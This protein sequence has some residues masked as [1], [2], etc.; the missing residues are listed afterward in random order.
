[1]G[2]LGR[3]DS[4]AYS[5]LAAFQH[6]QR[7]DLSIMRKRCVGMGHLEQRCRQPVAIRH[8]GLFDRTPC[9]PGAQSARHCTWKLNLWFLPITQCSIGVPHLM[10]GHLLGDLECTHVTGFLD[11]TFNRQRAIV[12]RVANG[13]AANVE[14]AWACFNDGMGR[15]A[16]RFQ[17]HSHGDRLHRRA[18]L[19]RVG[20]RAIAQLLTGQV[21]ALVGH[22]AGIICEGQHF[23]GDRV[24][25]H[26]AARFGPVKLYR[27]AQLLVSD[28]LYLAVQAQM[29]VLALQWRYLLAY[30]FHNSAEPVL[31]D[32]P[33]TCPPRELLVES[34]LNTFLSAVFNIRE[35][36]HMCCRLALRILALVFLALVNALD[37]KR[38]D[39][40]GNRVIDLPLDPDKA[41]VLIG[42][43]LVQFGQR[44]LKQVRQFDQL[45]FRR[46]DIFR[47][48]P[49]AGRRNA[50]SQDQA[51][52]VQ[53]A[54]P[55][56]WQL[57]RPGKAY[58]TLALEKII[59]KNL[60]ICGAG[61]QSGKRQRDPGNDELAAPHRRF[62]GQQGTRRV[63]HAATH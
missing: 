37:A 25:Y 36:D 31:D 35:A 1:M 62:T 55:V 54:A 61:R 48:G 27:V 26:N 18:R 28:K 13:E 7:N 34:K 5:G 57:Q 19:E 10:R 53:D 14:P 44:H 42:E 4:Y 45:P 41:L 24:K 6:G 15:D 63:E 3:K 56:G 11:Y 33:R 46:C 23:A 9:F 60:H 40:L 47:N 38:A 43:L 50:G 59:A 12:M 17:R 29:N 8:G 39:L 21:L 51:V 49:Y 58:F 30:I 52:A 20:Q 16:T 2:V 22:I 32:A